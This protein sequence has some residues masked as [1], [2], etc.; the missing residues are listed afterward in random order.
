MKFLHEFLSK[1]WLRSGIHSLR[2]RNDESSSADIIYVIIRRM[3]QFCASHTITWRRKLGH[4]IE[5]LIPSV[6]IIVLDWHV[7]FTKKSILL[8]GFNA[9]YWWFGGLPAV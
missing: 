6:D 5:Y 8:G 9:I 3:S 2:R 1:I 7:N 4:T